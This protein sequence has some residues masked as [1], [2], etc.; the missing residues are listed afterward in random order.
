MRR[1]HAYMQ[2]HA[3]AMRSL[4]RVRRWKSGTVR[5]RFSQIRK[6]SLTGER[7]RRRRPLDLWISHLSFVYLYPSAASTH[8][9]PSLSTKHLYH[10]RSSKRSKHALA[11]TAIC[12]QYRSREI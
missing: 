3:E 11:K 4:L 8:T 5:H 2:V 10:P 6:L 7:R 12:K 9:G 1:G